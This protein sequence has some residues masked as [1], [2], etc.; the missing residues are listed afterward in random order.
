MH[1][2]GRHF[3]SNSIDYMSGGAGYL[4]SRASLIIAVS[5]YLRDMCLQA[6]PGNMAMLPILYGL[7]N[8]M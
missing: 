3:T 2:T 8:R 5:Y 6:W 1:H 7:I 4:V